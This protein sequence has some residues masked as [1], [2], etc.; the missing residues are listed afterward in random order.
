MII[1]DMAKSKQV[2]K[3]RDAAQAKATSYAVQSPQRSQQPVK[4]L[5][6]TLLSGFLVRARVIGPGGRW[7][8]RLAFI[9]NPPFTSANTLGM[10]REAE[11]PRCCNTS[12]ALSTGY[13]S[14]LSSMILERKLPTPMPSHSLASTP[15]ECRAFRQ[16][17]SAR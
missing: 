2:A 17:A 15:R 12:S 5:P 16:V 6:V 1:V 11:R 4:A 3:S 10:H 14:P 7:S 9:I 13:V 8:C